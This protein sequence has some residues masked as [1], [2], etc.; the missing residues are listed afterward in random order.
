MRKIF[1]KNKSRLL[2]YSSSPCL[3]F[4]AI[5]RIIPK[6]TSAS[7]ASNSNLRNI[8]R[9]FS[10]AN[11]CPRGATYP[12]FRNTSNITS[13][14]IST[15]SIFA[16]TLC[17]FLRELCGPTSA[18]SVLNS[19]PVSFSTFNFE[20]STVSLRNSHKQTATACPKFIE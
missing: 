16:A 14:I 3:T 9:N 10:S 7:A 20:L 8:R 5:F 6:K 18:P 17:S 15:I 11:T 13:V 2:P 4:H 12:L 19:P 1:P